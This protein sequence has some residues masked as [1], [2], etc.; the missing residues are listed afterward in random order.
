MSRGITRRRNKLPNATELAINT[1]T[2][3]TSRAVHAIKYLV[4]RCSATV[5]M[6]TLTTIVVVTILFLL[7]LQALVVMQTRRR[8]TA[9]VP[10]PPER[11]AIPVIGHLHL[12]LKKPLHRTLADLAARHGDLFCLRF[13]SSR[14]AVVSSALVAQQCLRT[15]DTTFAEVTNKQLTL[16]VGQI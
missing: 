4:H 15:L 14:V 16:C 9:H 13:S 6:D 3:G 2:A 7:P 12:L 10:T 8:R 1:S 5:A 11:R